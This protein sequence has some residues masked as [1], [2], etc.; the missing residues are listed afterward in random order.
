MLTTA[1][2]RVHADSNSYDILL[3]VHHRVRTMVVGQLHP[4]KRQLNQK[5][6]SFMHQNSP[7]VS[8]PSPSLVSLSNRSVHSNTLALQLTNYSSM[9][10]PPTYRHVHIRDCTLFANYNHSLLPPTSFCYSTIASSSPSYSTA[11]PVSST[12]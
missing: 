10:T 7:P 11:P 4:T 5:N 12:Y 3:P 1:I 6:W 9:T 8:H 2:T